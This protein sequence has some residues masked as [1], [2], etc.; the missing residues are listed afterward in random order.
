MDTSTITKTRTIRIK[1]E[2]YDYFRDKP[3]NRVVE[4]IYERIRDGEIEIREDGMYVIYKYNMWRFEKACRKIG[5]APDVMFHN[6]IKGIEKEAE[7]E[8]SEKG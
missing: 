4:F 8:K 3:L 2:V 7:K 1:N 6:I 5:V